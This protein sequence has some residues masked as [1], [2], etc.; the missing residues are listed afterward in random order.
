VTVCVTLVPSALGF[1]SNEL[2]GETWSFQQKVFTNLIVG[3]TTYLLT[4]PFWKRS[5]DGYAEQ[6]RE[7]FTVMH[8]PVDFEK[9]VGEANDLRQLKVIGSFAVVIGVLI[10]SLMLLP[11]PLTGKLGILFVGGFVAAI[12]GLFLLIGRKRSGEAVS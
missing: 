8:T 4:I 6:V 3:T 2:F 5:P 7:F 1:F 12:G 9:E 11:N 10:C